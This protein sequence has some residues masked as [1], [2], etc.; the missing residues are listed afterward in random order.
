MN[1]L[2]YISRLRTRSAAALL[3]FGCA[4]G[5]LAAAPQ[6]G[7]G[8]P[9]VLRIAS[10][11]QGESYHKFAETMKAALERSGGAVRLEVVPTRGS[12]E[13]LGLIADGEVDLAIVQENILAKAPEDSGI[14]AM[15][16]LFTEVVHLFALKD[17]GINDILDL[18]GA[19][20]C[21]PAKGS[22]TR[23]DAQQILHG[24]GILRNDCTE[25]YAPVAELPR[26]LKENRAEAAFVTAAV[27]SRTVRKC[28][29]IVFLGLPD[30]I[31]N[32][33]LAKYPHFVPA[34]IPR[35]SY[36]GQ[37]KPVHSVGVRAVLVCRSGL[38]AEM[39]ENLLETTFSDSEVK[40]LLGSLGSG[41]SPSNL[42]GRGLPVPMHPG[43]SSYYRGR[44]L[45]LSR[46]ASWGGSLFLL[47]GVTMLWAGIYMGKPGF[48]KTV[49]RDIF[50]KLLAI[51][52]SIYVLATA[53]MH[54]LEKDRAEYFATLPRSFWSTSVYILSG[55]EDLGPRTPSGKFV[56]TILLFAS[57]GM[58]SSIA[59]KLASVFIE[60]KHHPMPK[61]LK[62][63]IVVCHWNS[64][65][66]AVVG[67]IH[68]PEA[69][70]DIDV[71]VLADIEIDEKHIRGEHEKDS[72][73]EKVFFA[74]G[75]PQ[76]LK[77][78]ETVRVER[79]R[80]VVILAKAEAP[81][82]DAH[83]ALTV[84][85]IVR[86]CDEKG[87]PPEKRPHIVVESIDHRKIDHLKAAGADE[88]VCSEHFSVG[89]LAQSAL[90]SEISDVYYRLLRFS[91]D[92]NEIYGIPA[93]DLPK[94][95]VGLSFG[96]VAEKF[97]R[98]R[99][100]D[101]NPAIPLGMRKENGEVILNPRVGAPGSTLEKDDLLLVVAWNRGVLGAGG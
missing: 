35:L 70:P 43:A 74:R 84:L 97:A 59:G 31:I 49:R 19:K 67:Q 66:E 75:D 8:A 7:V 37:N 6:G 28:P 47:F 80:S 69:A 9:I 25:I 63:H 14:E 56:A 17:S 16:C 15:A 99:A 4:S 44:F 42:A 48:L 85:A 71:A 23:G 78:L 95:F 89:V 57:A 22:G 64:L 1:P 58:V 21:I 86:Y 61:D 88:V 77:S 53:A 90:T 24:L 73:F 46:L 5:F 36:P 30:N 54:F 82:P 76:F 81:D 79:A 83:S 87:V 50:L 101:D 51:F 65:G 62:N 32:D 2:C 12:V 91:E 3:L 92:T 39:A 27:P 13:N 52:F 68:D 38:S 94:D 10:G 72:I 20:I 11:S 40:T 60:I 96:E 33:L 45:W 98:C 26:V 29:P 100:G 18:P 41:T 34:Q 55:I 93:A